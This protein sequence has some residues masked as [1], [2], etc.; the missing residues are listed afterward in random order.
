MSNRDGPH[1]NDLQWALASGFI[2]ARRVPGP[3]WL[4]L[5]GWRRDNAIIRRPGG[6]NTRFVK[7]VRVSLIAVRRHRRVPGPCRDALRCGRRPFGW[8]C[9]AHSFSSVSQPNAAVP[10]AMRDARVACIAGVRARCLGRAPIQ[11]AWRRARPRSQRRCGDARGPVTVCSGSLRAK[12]CSATTVTSPRRFDRTPTFRAASA[13]WTCAPCTKRPTAHCGHPRTPAASIAATRA[14]VTSRSFITIPRTRARSAMRV[15]SGSL[16]TPKATSGSEPRTVSIVST[17]MGATSRVSST[18]PKNGGSLANNW[19]YTLHLGP[20]KQFW[21]GTVGGGIDRWDAASNSF[22]HFSLSELARGHADLDRIFALH[23]TAD[24]RVWAGTRVGLVV[25]DPIRKTAAVLDLAGVPE[26]ENPLITDIHADQNNRLWLSTL[27]HGL[28][29]VDLATGQ[30]TRADTSGIGQ[31]GNL[32][33][34]GQTTVTAT[35]STDLRGYLGQRRVSR[36]RWTIRNS[37][38]SR[39]PRMAAVCATRM[40]RPCS[41]VRL[42][43]SPGLAALAEDPTRGCARGIRRADRRQRDRHDSSPPAS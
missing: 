23:E 4:R 14:R 22:E 31:Q 40:S 6:A 27:A 10:N 17:P 32:P 3:T 25:L 28:H 19:V 26:T 36:R 7:S 20:S 2:S 38:C 37:V 11:K 21:I 5:R 34:P 18:T 30:V 41:E 13:M 8:I 35:D 9:V 33:A 43:G 1:D 29:I 16:R 42:P 24:G 12:A 15:R 39:T